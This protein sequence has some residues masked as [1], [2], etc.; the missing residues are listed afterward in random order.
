M[1]LMLFLSGKVVHYIINHK[2]LIVELPKL[3]TLLIISKDGR[4]L[5]IKGEFD[6]I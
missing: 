3:K 4:L 2:H 6:K 1:L 5:I